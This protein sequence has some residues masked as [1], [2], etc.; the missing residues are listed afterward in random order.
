MGRMSGIQPHG[1]AH[2][3]LLVAEVVLADRG[4]HRRVDRSA[5]YA[6]GKIG[7]YRRLE[8]TTR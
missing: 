1:G 5:I 2:E 7:H 8:G 3:V 6:A 4:R